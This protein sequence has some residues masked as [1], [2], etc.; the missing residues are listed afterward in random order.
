MARVKHSATLLRE[1]SS[2]HWRIRP[3]WSG[4]RS[5]S[6]DFDPAK[7]SFTAIAN[8]SMARFNMRIQLCIAMASLDCRWWQRAEVLTGD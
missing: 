8:M 6:A 5:T 3:K 2:A 1:E 4:G 7:G